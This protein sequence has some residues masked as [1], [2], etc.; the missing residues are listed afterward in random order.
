MVRIVMSFVQSTR[1]LK[2]AEKAAQGR[3]GEETDAERRQ[4]IL[5]RKMRIYPEQLLGSKRRAGRAA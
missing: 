2:D 1:T 4:R 5:R 3:Y